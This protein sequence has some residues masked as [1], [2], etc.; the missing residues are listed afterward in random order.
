MEKMLPSIDRK[1][2]AQHPTYVVCNIQIHMKHINKNATSRLDT[3]NM[4]VKHM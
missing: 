3:C 4:S 1:N 2:P